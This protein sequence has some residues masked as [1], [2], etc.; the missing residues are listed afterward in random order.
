MKYR[1]WLVESGG[2]GNDLIHG[3][4]T[5]EE[6]KHDITLLLGLCPEDFMKNYLASNNTKRT[7]YH[8]VR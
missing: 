5:T 6:F 1:Q 2:E 7:K 8:Y 4:N 3:T